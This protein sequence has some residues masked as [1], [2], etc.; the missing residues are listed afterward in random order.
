MTIYN[1]GSINWDR[2]YH[3]A[4]FPAAGETISASGTDTGL[5]GKGLNQ[6]VAVIRAG[7]ELAHCGAIGAKDAPMAEA[8]K[9]LGIDTT[10]IEKV[11]NFG[12]GTALILLD[13]SGENS[14]ILEAGANHHISQQHIS[15]SLSNSRPGDWF[16]TQNET[17]NIEFGIDFARAQNMNI[18]FAA[19]PF[20]HNIVIPLL[21]KIDLLAVNQIEYEQILQ[22]LGSSQL[23]DNVAIFLTKGAAGIQ[24]IVGGQS[25][26][27]AAPSVEVVDTTGAGD[28]A[29]GSFLARLDQQFEH[30]EALEFAVFASA[31]QVT[32]S[33]AV[34]AI[35]ELH[36]V[37]EFA[38]RFA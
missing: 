28:T 8:L 29:L 4:H 21:E 3:L 22:A 26:E 37:E 38:G 13:S 19:A 16:L 17:N 23:P 6:S 5:G 11:D 2:I 35:P 1:L 32:R 36:E 9:S 12:T 7:G 10:A 20:D 25:L 24:Y 27:F 31:L 15:S 34:G 18:A 14:I 30:Q 33:G